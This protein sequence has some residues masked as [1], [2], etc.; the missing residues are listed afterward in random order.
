MILSA[1]VSSAACCGSS[2]TGR[3]SLR[4]SRPCRRLHYQSEAR[5]LGL[6]LLTTH[7]AKFILPPGAPFARMI[8]L[9]S[10]AILWL[11]LWTLLPAARGCST[12][13]LDCEPTAWQAVSARSMDFELYADLNYTA[14]LFP[15][16]A[17]LSAPPLCT[18]CPSRN[19]TLPLGFAALGMLDGE[20]LVD[21][22]N[23]AGLSAAYLWLS[24][25]PL[26]SNFRCLPVCR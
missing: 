16:G 4:R 11:C 22:M 14:N 8:G 21:G 3:F 18:A 13:I 25:S 24:G 1:R 12:F 7:P 19:Y 17:V 10:A 15:P 20:V 2:R 26:Q 6:L 9:W 5:F 23:E